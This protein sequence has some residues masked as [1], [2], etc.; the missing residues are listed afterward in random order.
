VPLTIRSR[1]HDYVVRFHADA[2]FLRDLARLPGAF[3]VVDRR[4]WQHYGEV[5]PRLDESR[6]L[7]FDAV[8]DKKSLESVSGLWEA[9][10]AGGIRR[11]STLVAV[12]GGIV[13]DVTGFVASTLYRGIR[14]VYVPTTLLSQADSCIGSKT[15]LNWKGTKNAVGTFYPPHEVHVSTVFLATLTDAD[16]ESGLGEVLKL[17]LIGGEAATRKLGALLP[18]V[19]AREAA[20]VLEAIDG[21]LAVKVGFIEEDEFDRGR[22][23]H[24]NFGH[25]LGHAIEATS[26]FAVPHGQAVV[27]GMLFAGCIAARRELLPAALKEQVDRLLVGNCG[28]RPTQEH[29]DPARVHAAM[30]RDKKRVGTGLPLVM[31]VDGHQMVKVDDL[32]RP[33][34]DRGLEELAGLLGV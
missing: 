2:S 4:V 24:L 15:S 18:R 1:L 12:G 27:A 23:N 26:D 6:V 20:A 7:L 19:K 10:I 14:W 28:V 32:G 25:C 8:E 30:S 13:Q 17:F 16:F 3:W 5:I 21:A 33:E 29:L 31:M 9:L 11:S 34:L 22:R